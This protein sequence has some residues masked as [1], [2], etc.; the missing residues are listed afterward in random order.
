VN[1]YF[2]VLLSKQRSI[3]PIN[4][5]QAALCAQ[6]HQELFHLSLQLLWDNE[7]KHH[8]HG[9]ETEIR[10]LEKVLT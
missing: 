5:T 3:M 2:V 6:S 7:K 4:S 8:K 1:N 9:L 10:M